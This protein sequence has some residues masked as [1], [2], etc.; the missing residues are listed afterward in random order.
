MYP[1]LPENFAD[2]S[3]AELRTLALQFREARRLA[4]TEHP[5]M[6]KEQ[7]A[8]WRAAGDVADMLTELAHDADKVELDAAI[9][10][11][12]TQA[13]EAL[14][15]NDSPEA[16]PD[17]DEGGEDEGGED[18]GGE[19]EGGGLSLPSSGLSLPSEKKIL[20]PA[21]SRWI[22][23]PDAGSKGPGEKQAFESTRQIGE[24]VAALMD[25]YGGSPDRE[26]VVAT[27]PGNW[28]PEQQL[29]GTPNEMFTDWARIA[30]PNQSEIEAAFCTPFQN[31]YELACANVT[32]RPVFN[33]LPT[34]TMNVDRGGINIPESPSLTDIT[35]GY[36]QW[37][38]ASDADEQ[39]IKNCQTIDCVDWNDFEW[40]AVY[41]CLKVKNMMQM[42]FPELVDAY[43]N[44]LQAAWARYAEILLLE[45]MG[46]ASTA[47]DSAWAAQGYGANVTVQR[48]I[49]NYL[50]KYADIE[51]WDEPV[52][53]AWMPRWF[54]WALR[55]DIA[56]RR[57]DAGGTVPSVATIEQGFRDVGVEPH[58]YMDRP[59]WATAFGNG[60]GNPF[61]VNGDLVAFPTTVQILIHRRG[62][63]AVI[64]KGQLQLGLGG[65]PLRI[66]E[67]VRR[68]QATFFFESFEGL[69]DTDSCPAHLIT[70][71]GLCYNGGQIADVA[72]GCSG[73]DIP[74][75]GSS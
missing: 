4:A 39:A 69:V 46:T 9:V 43:L 40:Y 25:S 62:K 64:N 10:L 30:T 41:R 56:S 51:R 13:L 5:K 58:W 11:S 44:R 54:L 17:G 20:T 47:V 12:H 70:I 66:E 6:D 8:E 29:A 24:T 22:A 59:T 65:N 72:I 57:K 37:T 14:D 68:N 26:L 15:A 42:V 52:M 53:D 18:E 63:F 35:T 21:G 67:D 75:F 36:G 48:V 32:R 38:S 71:P 45:Q 19:D 55:M 49:L 60:T 23:G 3:A 73:N 61:S 27:M 28:R 34:F 16:E 1:Q 2:L 7:M 74:G 31:S 33:G 50:G